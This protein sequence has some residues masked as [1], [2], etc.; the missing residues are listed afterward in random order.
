MCKVGED[1][2]QKIYNNKNVM[3]ER[4]GKIG[5]FRSRKT[6]LNYNE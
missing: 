2:R 6:K 4:I 3:C 1:F 5:I